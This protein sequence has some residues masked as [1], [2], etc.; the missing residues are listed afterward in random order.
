MQFLQTLSKL[1]K[2]NIAKPATNSNFMWCFY[3]FDRYL[4]NCIAI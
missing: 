2:L 3:R 1:S 4:T